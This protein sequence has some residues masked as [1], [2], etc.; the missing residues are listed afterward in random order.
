MASTTMVMATMYMSTNGCGPHAVKL[1]R[2]GDV[3]CD[4]GHEATQPTD[5][6]DQ[7]DGDVHVNEGG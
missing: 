1:H 2:A 5:D 3:R 4:D 6:N 7:G